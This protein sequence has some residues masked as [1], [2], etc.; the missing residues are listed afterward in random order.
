MAFLPCHRPKS[1]G[2]IPLCPEISEAMTQSQPFLPELFLLGICYSDENHLQSEE[3]SKGVLHFELTFPAHKPMPEEWRPYWLKVFGHKLKLILGW[4]LRYVDMGLGRWHRT[5]CV[6][7]LD[8]RISLPTGDMCIEVLIP[9]QSGLL[10][11]ACIAMWWNH[12]WVNLLTSSYCMDKRMQDLIA[13]SG[14]GQ[15][16][17][18]ISYPGSLPSPPPL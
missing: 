14:P 10:R 12:Q 17:K 1:D 2:A 11:G 15:V 16:F 9:Q 18:G 7:G 8:M 4:I 13:G 6:C 3:R 5:V